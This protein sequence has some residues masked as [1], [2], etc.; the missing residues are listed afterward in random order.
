M[1]T[2]CVTACKYYN[3]LL[4]CVTRATSLDSSLAHF[5]DNCFKKTQ[6]LLASIWSATKSFIY[7]VHWVVAD[8]VTFPG[9]GCSAAS[10]LCYY[11]LSLGVC[12]SR[13][14]LQFLALSLVPSRLIFFFA[15]TLSTQFLLILEDT[16]TRAMQCNYHSAI[17]LWVWFSTSSSQKTGWG[18]FLSL[19]ISGL[20]KVYTWKVFWLVHFRPYYSLV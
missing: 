15:S 1:Q 9:S 17:N 6:K 18:I 13:G 5:G 19:F 4:I 3:F 10:Y 12:Y 7:I 11:L 16:V 20:L 2:F 8:S 14:Q